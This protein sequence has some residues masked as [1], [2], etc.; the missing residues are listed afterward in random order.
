LAD[1]DVELGRSAL[2]DDLLDDAF[3]NV[4]VRR[5]G[6]IFQD[7]DILRPDVGGDPVAGL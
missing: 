7:G 1:L 6:A 2:E 5:A 4:T 3:N